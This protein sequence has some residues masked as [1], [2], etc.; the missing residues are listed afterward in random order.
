LKSAK[1]KSEVK[2]DG[3]GGINRFGHMDVKEM[4]RKAVALA[5][6]TF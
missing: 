2:I 5:S 3:A 4:E 6:A 1:D